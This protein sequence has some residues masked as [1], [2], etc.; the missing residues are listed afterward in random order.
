MVLT[1]PFLTC[2]C[3]SLLNVCCQSHTHALSLL[4]IFCPSLIHICS[5][6]PVSDL[7]LLLSA[8]H[9]PACS[10]LTFAAVLHPSKLSSSMCPPLDCVQLTALRPRG[11]VAQWPS[12]KAPGASSTSATKFLQPFETAVANPILLQNTHTHNTYTQM[13]AHIDVCLGLA[14]IFILYFWEEYTPILLRKIDIQ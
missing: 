2:Y 13:H 12:T 6:F 11:S 1:Q 8:Y 14:V 9:T 10:T 4:I 3:C 7:L 5:C